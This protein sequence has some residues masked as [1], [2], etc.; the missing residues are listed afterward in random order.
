MG[1]KYATYFEQFNPAR[2]RTRADILPL[3]DIVDQELEE[4]GALLSAAFLKCEQRKQALT[5]QAA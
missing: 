3:L 1:T 4:I 5:A 2:P